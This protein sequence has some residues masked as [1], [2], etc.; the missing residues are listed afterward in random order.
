MSTNESLLK[1]GGIEAVILRKTVKNLHL[2]V[3]PP[4]GKVRVTAPPDMG[5][6]AIRTF[7]ATRLGWIKKQQ[8]KFRGQERQTP[9]EYVSGETHYYFGKKY[10]LELVEENIKPFV[11]LKGKNKILLSVRPKSDILKRE[12]IMQDWYRGELRTFLTDMINK[13]EKRIGVK[14]VKWGIRR[15]KTRW[16]TCNH[17]AKTIWLNL[18]LVKKPESCIEYAVVHELI[19]LIEEKHSNKFMALMDKHLPKWK[20]EKEELNRLILAHENWL[21]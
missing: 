8:S 10:R 16:G 1:V 19:H 7:L 18:E 12:Q 17:K 21:N 3:L 13:W 2:N 20:S 6:D 9:R 15:M 5:D 14:A 4:A 11:K